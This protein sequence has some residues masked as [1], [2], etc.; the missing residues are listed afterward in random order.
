MTVSTSVTGWTVN[1]PVALS[2]MFSD[3]QLVPAGCYLV[4]AVDGGPSNPGAYT[5]GTLFVET[6][7]TAAFPT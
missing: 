3:S 6:V 7:R 4:W 2:G 1:T 5:A